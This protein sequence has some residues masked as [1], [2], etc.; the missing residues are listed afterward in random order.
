MESPLSPPTNVELSLPQYTCTYTARAPVV[1]SVR[2]ESGTETTPVASSDIFGGKSKSGG[3]RMRN[4]I[5]P[6]WG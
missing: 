3:T 6:V 5:H 2:E 4:R 1:V